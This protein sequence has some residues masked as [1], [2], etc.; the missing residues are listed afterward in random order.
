MRLVYDIETVQAEVQR[1]WSE[2]MDP[3]YP[4][5]EHGE[6]PWGYLWAATIPCNGCGRWFPLYG[7]N[8]LRKPGKGDEGQSFETLTDGDDWS[9]RIVNG[10][11]HQ[12]PT[13]HARKRSIGKLAW[14]S[15]P[16]CGHAHEAAEHRRLSA[17]HF[18]DVTLLV[19]ADLTA[20]EK[21]FRLPSSEDLVASASAVAELPKVQLRTR[22]SAKPDE[23]IARK[24]NSTSVQAVVYGARTFGVL[25]RW[26]GRTL[27]MLISR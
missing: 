11:T 6:K 26:R 3:Y 10:Q 18:G 9:I 19:V 23:V 2:V 15:F 8:T 24:V 13:M 20:G 22:L 14:C 4:D 21:S 17:D 12:E 1:R 5:N 25:P 7:S 27:P 16:D